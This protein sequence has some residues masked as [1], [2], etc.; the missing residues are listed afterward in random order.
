MTASIRRPSR[1]RRGGALATVAALALT[2]MS[3]VGAVSAEEPVLIVDDF[4]SGLPTGTDGDGITIGFNTFQDPDSTVAI[5]TATPPTPVPGIA[6]PNQALKVDLNV[7]AFA[8]VTHTF[9]NETSDTWV[10][11]DWSAS[12]GF[13][14]WLYGQNSGTGL[15]VDV[16]ENRKPDSTTDDA[17]RWRI[18]PVGSGGPGCW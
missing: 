7:V 12:E 6:E 13:T 11:Q 2:M 4:E 5:S 8:G 3:A 9:M 1:L 17:E 15:F 14:M 18:A 16:L 10:S